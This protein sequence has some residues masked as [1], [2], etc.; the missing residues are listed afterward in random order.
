MILSIISG[1]SMD[2][3]GRPLTHTG[4][5]HSSLGIK[6]HFYVEYYILIV[7]MIKFQYPWRR[8]KTSK[9]VN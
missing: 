4:L 9:V 3:L 7:S 5:P 1:Q 2:P 8:I 6:H